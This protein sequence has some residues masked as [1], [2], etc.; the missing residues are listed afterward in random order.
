MTEWEAQSSLAFEVRQLR[1]DLDD[2][3]DAISF[4]P[5]RLRGLDSQLQQARKETRAVDAFWTGYQN[6]PGIEALLPATTEDLLSRWLRML[7]EDLEAVSLDYVLEHHGPI[8]GELVPTS[9]GEIEAE[10]DAL[11]TPGLVRRNGRWAH[12]GGFVGAG[13][14]RGRHSEDFEPLWDEMTRLYRE[15]AGATW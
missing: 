9:T 8:G 11:E 1:S 6:V 14:R 4:L 13:G 2:L 3:A 12:E 10:S 5:G 15:H 7:G